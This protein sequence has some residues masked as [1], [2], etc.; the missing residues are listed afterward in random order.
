MILLLILLCEVEFL[1]NKF[2]SYIKKL[3]LLCRI[4]GLNY[5]HNQVLCVGQLTLHRMLGWQWTCFVCLAVS[6]KRK[7]E[8]SYTVLNPKGKNTPLYIQFKI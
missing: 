5:G 2:E 1:A 7:C 3:I 6:E 8:D 4:S